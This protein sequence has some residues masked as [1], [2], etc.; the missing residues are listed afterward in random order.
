MHNA[1]ATL[2]ECVDSISAQ[3]LENF[4]VVIVDDGSYD[5]SPALVAAHAQKDPRFRLITSHKPGLVGALNTGLEHAHAPL[6]ARMDADDVMHHERLALQAEF[7]DTHPNIDVLGTRVHAFP[8]AEIHAGMREYLRWQNTCIDI[9]ALSEEIFIESPFTHPSVM[10]KRDVVLAA[11]G[12]REGDFPEDYEL[13]LRMN[14]HGSKFAKLEATLLE[15]RQNTTSLSRTDPRYAK[16]AFDRIRATYLHAW[17]ERV[18]PRPIAIW[19]AGRRTRRRCRPLQDLGVEVS[20]W[21]DI[22]PKKIGQSLKGTKVRPPAWLE[23]PDTQQPF[24]LVYV[25]NHGA[26]DL[27]GVDLEQLGYQRAR[28]YLMVG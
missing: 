13:W 11:G 2:D 19:G 21:I 8:D 14:A 22:D 26:R 17:L 15:W 4:E 6:I 25:A 28:D 7:F 9:T 24:V 5:A 16:D 12:Y 27:I 23:S 3:T 20:A 18:E 10:Y 1:A